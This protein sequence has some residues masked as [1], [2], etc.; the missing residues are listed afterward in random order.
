MF[1]WLTLKQESGYSLIESIFQLVIFCI[2]VHFIVLFFLWKTPVESKMAD[3]YAIEWELFA[4]ELQEMLAE[5]ST[6]NVLVG[7]RD[8]VFKT[9]RGDIEIGQRGAVIRKTVNQQG[10]VPMYT[11][12]AQVIFSRH[13]EELHMEVTMLDG[14]IRERRFAIGLRQE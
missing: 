1:R 6:F 2:F 5:V 11:N 4:I 3:Y 8:I 14:R 7:D 12:V 10:Y 13:D 9:N